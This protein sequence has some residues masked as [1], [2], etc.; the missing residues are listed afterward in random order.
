M[1]AYLILIF[2]VA[3][4]LP[5]QGAEKFYTVTPYVLP[6]GVK[7]EAS[8]MALLPDGRLAVAVRKG[9]VWMLQHPEAD[10]ANPEAVGYKLFAS[11]LHEPLGLAWHDGALLTVQ[12]SELTKL[13]DTDGDGE[14][15]EYLTVAKGWGV[16]G[17]Y[18]E[19]A[20]GPVV[21]KD[22][23]L[24]LTLNSTLGKGVEMAGHRPKEKPWRGWAMRVTPAGVL[25]PMSAGLRSPCGLGTN[26]AGDVFC[27]DQQGNWWGTN[28][29]MHLRKGAFFGH[30][31][32]IPDMSRPDSPIK[33]PGKLP[34]NLTVALAIKQVPGLV[35]PAVWFPYVKAG[36][37]PTG[38][39]CDLSGGKFGPFAEQM[40]VGEFVLSGVNRVFLEK[41]NGEYQGAVFRFL[42]G[43]QSAALS[44][45]FLK[46][47]SLLVG[48]SNRGWN[49]Q[50]TR[51]F[52]L[53]R[54][55]WTGRTPFAIQKME[56]QPDGFKL[57]F[58]Q[59][60][61]AALASKSENF[62]VSSYTYLYHQ[63]YG[64]DEVDT[65]PV[66][67]KEAL[68]ERDGLVVRL[69]CEGLREGYVHELQAAALKSA[70][71]VLLEPSAAFYTLNQLP[72]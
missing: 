21:D 69:K 51:S 71:G 20:Y 66:A 65:K 70:D 36:Q 7:L 12:R 16:S 15:D 43:L 38:M 2:L 32:S 52:G 19:Y 27:S 41:V 10:P 30:A 26:A 68:V 13:R 17:N 25:E 24:W 46:D 4:M 5:L 64:S 56:A 6:D 60:V 9:E 55:R 34:Q 11:G 62:A 53:E 23:N 29:L 57:T 42:D 40:F 48:E 50:G 28:P 47:G 67:V 54:I 35:P 14:A 18:H 8:G 31:D 49:S 63:T 58:T 37:S 45:G 72:K 39:A 61:D 44:L 22:Q 1:Q 59:P 3:A 33:P